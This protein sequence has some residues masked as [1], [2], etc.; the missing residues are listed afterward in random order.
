MGIVMC[1]YMKG[2]NG[3]V[4]KLKAWVVQVLEPQPT[5]QIQPIPCSQMAMSYTFFLSMVSGYIS[6]KDSVKMDDLFR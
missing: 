4:L 2:N 6:T 3:P 1:I 5:G